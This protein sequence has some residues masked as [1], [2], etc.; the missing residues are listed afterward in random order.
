QHKKVEVQRQQSRQ[1]FGSQRLCLVPHTRRF[2]GQQSWVVEPAGEKDGDAR[3]LSP[4]SPRLRFRE[5]R[6]PGPT[7]EDYRLHDGF[8][9]TQIRCFSLWKKEGPNTFQFAGAEVARVV[10][11]GNEGTCA[12]STSARCP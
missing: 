6:T 5:M 8:F 3:F 11:L 7:W 9:A 2:L 1:P 12:D 10:F 4:S